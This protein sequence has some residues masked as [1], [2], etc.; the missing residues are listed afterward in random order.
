M[1]G[2]AKG[3]G[4]IKPRICAYYSE[5]QLA[6]LKYVSYNILYDFVHCCCV[7]ICFFTSIVH[8]PSRFGWLCLQ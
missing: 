4:A 3:T 8:V 2:K 6:A 1:T 7:C 5:D